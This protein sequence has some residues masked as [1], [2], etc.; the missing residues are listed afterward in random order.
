IFPVSAM[1]HYPLTFHCSNPARFSLVPSKI[2]PSTSRFRSTA[3]HLSE[4]KGTRSNSFH[5]RS[6]RLAKTSKIFFLRYQK[7]NYTKVIADFKICFT[8]SLIAF[9]P[10]SL[11]IFYSKYDHF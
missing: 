11:E 1:I 10:V 8:Q 9:H 5:V 7:K 4:L 6:I 2:I 3:S